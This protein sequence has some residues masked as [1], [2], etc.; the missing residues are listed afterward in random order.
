MTQKIK[1]RFAPSPTGRIH[2]GNARTAIITWIAAR[3]MGGEFMLRIDDTDVERS[4]D[5]HVDEIKRVLTWLG[6]NWDDYAHQRDRTDRYE[7]C[8]EKL[9]ADGRLYPCYE[10]S[11]QLDLKRKSLLN[12]GLPPI[13]DRSALGLTDAEKAKF[14]AEGRVPHWRFKLNHAPIEWNDLVRDAVKFDG[15]TMS[16]PVL[17]RENG[18]P[19]YHLCSVIDDIDFEITHVTRGEDHVSNT[20]AHIQMFEALGATPPQFAHLPLLS[21]TEGEKLSKRI[22][23]LALEDMNLEGGFEAM[24]IVSFLSR[25][26]TSMPIEAF[27]DVK[28][29]IETFD[30]SKFSRGTPKVDPMEIERINAKIVHDY[31]YDAVKNRAE[32]DGV[33]EALWNGVKANLVKVKDVQNWV[34]VTQE[35]L[36]VSVADEDKD[37]IKTALSCLPEGEITPE[38]WGA[39]T[40]VLKEQTDRKGRALFMPLRQALT[41]MDHGPEMDKMLLLLGRDRTARRLEKAG[42]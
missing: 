1:Y 42:A 40:S 8:I 26:G 25:L 4:K 19:L 12:R 11:E 33:D 5:E 10:T 16:D 38:S 6:L 24:A 9:K 29:L 36:D 34:H 37:Y 28:D 32:L 21:G 17:I 2:I 23:S 39:W 41:G 7:E 15:A 18:T 35:T 31:D 27:T 3:A 14:E 13:Y 20:A 22:G 30:F